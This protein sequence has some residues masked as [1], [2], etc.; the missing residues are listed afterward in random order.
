MKI[1]LLDQIVRS[2]SM[3]ER[4]LLE[5][6][7]VQIGSELFTEEQL[8]SLLS[9]SKGELQLAL[10]SLRLS[11]LVFKAKKMWGEAVYSIPKDVYENLIHIFY[12]DL[13][14]SSLIEVVK[15]ANEASTIHHLEYGLLKLGHYTVHKGGLRVT[16]KGEVYKKELQQLKLDKCFEQGF[17]N[18]IKRK[19]GYDGIY[20]PEEAIVLDC[21]I[22]LQFFK[23]AEDKWEW[24]QNHFKQWIEKAIPLRRQLLLDLIR[25]NLFPSSPALQTAW[26]IV[27]TLPSGCGI[28]ASSLVQT[29]ERNHPEWSS[30]ENAERK[31][32]E[33]IIHPL[34]ALDFLSKRNLS[35]G[36][37]VYYLREEREEVG[38]FYVQPDGHIIVP[39]QLSAVLR[40]ELLFLAEQ[41]EETGL[42]RITP[43]SLHQALD[44]GKS[45]QAILDFFEAHSVYPI[46]DSFKDQLAEWMASYGKAEVIDLQLLR[47]SNPRHAELFS[48]L[49]DSERY[50]YSRHRNNEYIVYANLMDE[51]KSKL[52][53]LQCAL[54]E[55]NQSVRAENK[56]RKNESNEPKENQHMLQAIFQPHSNPL[57]YPLEG[58]I[59]EIEELY[60]DLDEI[61]KMWLH[62]MR[63]YHDS[64]MKELCK[65]AIDLGAKLKLKFGRRICQ[66]TPSA[67]R[68][69][70]RAWAVKCQ[71][72][73]G[74]AWLDPNH[75]EEI[76]LILPGIND[77]N[78]R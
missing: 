63:S 34:Y 69:E 64:T 13:M 51:W 45:P 48:L 3:T 40:W 72:K 43:S 32:L 20:K 16:G 36:S 2:L 65:K 29:I 55:S 6:V 57:L 62:H 35:D 71:D 38:T 21:A 68:E 25:E 77:K 27:M 15:E 41:T 54:M 12:S 37:D 19:Y 50:I 61:P 70:R 53:E 76:Q 73:Q 33:A 17:L 9:L 60:Q 78:E 74:T 8:F 28:T 47:F 7:V 18:E 59:P 49:P 44:Q 10:R 30:L 23:K 26:A 5:Q 58:R 22:K 52:K 31:V 42:M 66:V 56:K 4:K 11:G 46:S 14:Q 67:M 24:D 39:P 75:W 1:D